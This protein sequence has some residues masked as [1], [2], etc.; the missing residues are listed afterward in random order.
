[1][2]LASEPQT[3]SKRINEGEENFQANESI[4]SSRSTINASCGTLYT[5]NSDPRLQLTSSAEPDVARSLARSDRLET[6]KS[7][8]GA[9][10]ISVTVTVRE[11]GKGTESDE[12]TSSSPVLTP[13]SS[14][15]SLRSLYEKN[16][17]AWNLDIDI[18]DPTSAMLSSGDLTG[19][20]MSKCS[21]L[22]ES[23]SDKNEDIIVPP[24]RTTGLNDSNDITTARSQDDHS[25][26]EYLLPLSRQ[27]TGS[28]MAYWSPDEEVRMARSRFG[29]YGVG[30]RTKQMDIQRPTSRVSPVVVQTI[31]RPCKIQ[32]DLKETNSVVEESVPW[33]KWLLYSLTKICP[34]RIDMAKS[35]VEMVI[36]NIPG[37]FEDP[38]ISEVR[39]KAPSS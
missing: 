28:A 22:E 4:T 15:A 10:T 27:N 3:M 18:S 33:W 7:D 5:C 25:K 32:I 19:A 26:M 14:T 37:S 30:C 8:I 24:R 38:S 39:A 20:V 17:R 34:A 6:H 31:S 23:G 13:S 11:L 9:R 1:M 29:R 35:E 36:R 12:S 2:I 16:L 21:P